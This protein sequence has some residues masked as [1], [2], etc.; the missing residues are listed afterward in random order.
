MWRASCK[1]SAWHRCVTRIVP[2]RW[3][4]ASR[5]TRCNLRE[6]QRYNV[7][8]IELLG[9]SSLWW[10]G[11]KSWG[12]RLTASRLQRMSC[13]TRT[14]GTHAAGEKIS[15]IQISPGTR[16]FRYVARATILQRMVFLYP[17]FW[18]EYLASINL[19]EA[20]NASYIIENLPAS[21]LFATHASHLNTYTDIKCNNCRPFWPREMFCYR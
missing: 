17:S 2:P 12:R 8:F 4:H 18:S 5:A 19:H 1:T 6:I 10:Y 3:R 11:R 21:F 16:A 15:R 9:G 14:W 20:C 13:E 7:F